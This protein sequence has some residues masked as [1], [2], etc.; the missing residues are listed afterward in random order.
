MTEVKERAES[1]ARNVAWRSVALKKLDQIAAAIQAREVEKA[2]EALF[3]VGWLQGIDLKEA[4]SA[5]LSKL[6]WYSVRAEHAVEKKPPDVEAAL[7]ALGEARQLIQNRRWDGVDC[8]CVSTFSML[9][10]TGRRMPVGH[11]EARCHH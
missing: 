6:C 1:L 4:R 5:E 9:P 7:K 2:F 8:R 10:R 3:G 11:P